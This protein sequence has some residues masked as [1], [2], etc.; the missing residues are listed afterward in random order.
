EGLVDLEAVRLGNAAVFER[1]QS[2]LDDLQR[3]LVLDLLDAETGRRLVLDDEALH[4][5]VAEVTRPD[6]RD[7]APRRVADPFLLAV[8][9]PGVAFALR[10]GGE[11]AA[12]SGADQRLGEAE[13]ADLLEARH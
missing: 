9:D 8:Q 10:R 11:A 3:D 4:L 2:V 12:R 1:D 7:V 5:V 13:A 6:D